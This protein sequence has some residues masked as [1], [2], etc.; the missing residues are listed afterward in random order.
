MH[1]TATPTGHLTALEHVSVATT[2][3]NEAFIRGV[4][5]SLGWT[6]TDGTPEGRTLDLSRDRNMAHR[7]ALIELQRRCESGLDK[8][9]RLETSA[10]T[11]ARAV[12]FAIGFTGL[13]LVALAVFLYLGAFTVLFFAAAALGL[14]LCGA[15]PLIFRAL[16]IR[17]AREIVSLIDAEYASLRRA[18]DEAA[19]LRDSD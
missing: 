8:I 11:R 7:V 12:A 16:K 9:A 17:R 5:L 4:Y 6:V 19:S 15:P 2:D 14:I 18:C 3:R 10:T 13:A 1:E